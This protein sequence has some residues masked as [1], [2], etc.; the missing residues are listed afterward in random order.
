MATKAA[1]ELWRSVQAMGVFS[2]HPQLLIRRSDRQ[3]NTAT[4][5]SQSLKFR[6]KQTPVK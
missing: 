4:P 6:S 5:R 1:M 2:F 3:T